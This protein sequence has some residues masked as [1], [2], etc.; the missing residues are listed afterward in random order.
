M[1]EKRSCNRITGL[2]L[3]TRHAFYHLPSPSV[4]FS[5]FASK[6][7][8]IKI[9]NSNEW[10]RFFCSRFVV[11]FL[12]ISLFIRTNYPIDGNTTAADCTENLDNILFTV[13]WT[14][15]IEP[16]NHRPHPTTTKPFEYVL[17]RMS[18][19][20]HAKQENAKMIHFISFYSSSAVWN[21]IAA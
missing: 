17:F 8:L 2:F 10:Q 3:I 11:A 15:S 4:P 1:R 18:A 19:R 12:I 14:M 5:P 20:L 13:I 21:E 7:Y 6:W 9:F 16:W